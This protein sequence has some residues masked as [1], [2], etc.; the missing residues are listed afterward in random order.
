MRAI[1]TATPTLLLADEEVEAFP[2]PSLCTVDEVMSRDVITARADTALQLVGELMLEHGISGVPVIDAEW[3]LL[4]VV[5]KT[6]LVRQ[7]LEAGTS[8]EAETHLA[9]GH[10]VL[11]GTVAEDVMSRAVVCVRAGASLAH[12]ARVMATAGVHRVPVVSP[13][14]RL[15]GVVSTTDLVR[16]M[17]GLPN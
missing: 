11:E 5:S 12:A 14:G 1:Q 8:G 3:R 7:S 2:A 9:S 16:W 10:H 6:D 13:A 15:V 17:A 4:G